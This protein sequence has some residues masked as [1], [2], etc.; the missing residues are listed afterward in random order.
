MKPGWIL[1]LVML[2]D[3]TAITIFKFFTF[4][5]MHSKQ[6]KIFGFII[7]IAGLEFRISTGFQKRQTFTEVAES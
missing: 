5:I 6:D 3:L 1:D 7:V 4:A 2:K